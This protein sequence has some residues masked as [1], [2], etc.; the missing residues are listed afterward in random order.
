M[1][2]EGR[3][4]TPDLAREV[5]AERVERVDIERQRDAAVAQFREDR[6]RV[7]ESVVGEAIGVISG[8]HEAMVWHQS[9]RGQEED[10][11]GGQGTPRS[12]SSRAELR[13]LFRREIR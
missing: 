12:L 13:R 1:A 5:V 8:D 3:A 7:L 9:G 10:G 6:Q 11:Q 2:L 4:D